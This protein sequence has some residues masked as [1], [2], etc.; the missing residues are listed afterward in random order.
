MSG[1]AGCFYSLCFPLCHGTIVWDYEQIIAGWLA[2][3]TGMVTSQPTYKFLNA[4]A[5][6]KYI[7]ITGK[8]ES[9]Q[10]ASLCVICCTR[11]MFLF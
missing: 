9:T 6:K 5:L 3:W 8:I 10:K 4:G 2:A 1:S 11:T 7:Y